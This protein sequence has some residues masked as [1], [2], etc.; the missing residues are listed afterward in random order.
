VEPDRDWERS[1][2]LTIK[3]VQ[4]GLDGKCIG[5]EYLGRGALDRVLAG[6]FCRGDQENRCPSPSGALSS[7]APVL[8]MPLPVEAYAW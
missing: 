7:R 4:Q 3:D 5:S 6:R 1:V 2:L 8:S